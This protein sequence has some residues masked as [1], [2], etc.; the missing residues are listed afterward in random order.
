MPDAL[1]RWISLVLQVAVHE[2][3]SRFTATRFGLLL[4]LAEPFLLVIIIVVLRF[5]LVRDQA[6]PFGV[7][8]LVFYSSGVFPFYIFIRLSERL[9]RAGSGRGIVLPGVTQTIALVGGTLAE[10]ALILCSLILWFTALYMYGLEEAAPFYLGSCLAALTGLWL[11]GFGFGLCNAALLRYFSDFT[12]FIWLWRRITGRRRMLI[13][14]SGVFFIADLL[15][16]AHRNVIV[17]NPLVHGIEWFRWGLYGN[18][19]IMTLDIEY[20]LMTAAG[21]FFLS[22]IAFW[23]T[24]R[25]AR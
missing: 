25:I 5:V 20:F 1:R 22:I 7:S 12:V 9:Q 11:I 16:F 19:P 13:F 23:S 4:A 14:V 21:I 2:L 6:P 15:P 8:T 3:D 10:S 24:I 17:W 18:Y